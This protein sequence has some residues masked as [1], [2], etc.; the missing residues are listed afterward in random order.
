VGSNR[1]KLLGVLAA[2]AA[3]ASAGFVF[4]VVDDLRH[5]YRR[6]KLWWGR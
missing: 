3:V 1:Y 2:V 6:A 4:F 5:R